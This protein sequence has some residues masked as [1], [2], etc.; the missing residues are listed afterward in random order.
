MIVDGA[1]RNVNY[2]E[3]PFERS[4]SANYGKILRLMIFDSR[5]RSW[6]IK[7]TFDRIWPAIRLG[8]VEFLYNSNGMA[9]AFATW[10][11]LS[12]D[13]A[14][15]FVQD[16]QMRLDMDQWNEGSQLWIIDFFS[17]RGRARDLCRKMKAL[18]F[19]NAAKV[20]GVRT[21]VSGRRSRSISLHI[22]E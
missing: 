2:V 22:R 21:Y 17:I 4:L 20:Q 19:K 14:T 11:F 13:V 18:H 1:N 16:P 5:M 3:S 7:H 9:I 15:Q 10:A 12:E 8:Q 6:D